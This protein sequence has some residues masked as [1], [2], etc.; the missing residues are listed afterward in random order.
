M[1][2]V[3]AAQWPGAVARRGGLAR[4]P[5]ALWTTVWGRRVDVVSV[6]EARRRFV[7]MLLNGAAMEMQNGCLRTT[8]PG[9]YLYLYFTFTCY[10][11][12]AVQR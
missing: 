12:W 4:W 7:V 5:G 3:S 2:G 6:M 11:Y 9:C 10:L 1:S 8:A